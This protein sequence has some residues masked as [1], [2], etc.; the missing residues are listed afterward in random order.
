LVNIGIIGAGN[1]GT[2][3]GQIISKLPGSRVVAVTDID[4]M[5]AQ[6]LASA[7]GAEVEPDPHRLA[8]R[9]DID[10]VMITTPTPFHREY[11]EQA[12]AAGKHV[13]C[14]KPLARSFEDGQA[15]LAAA[16]R[17]GI[18]LGIGHVVRWFPEYEQARQLI[19]EGVIGQ[20]GTART[21]R[22]V[23]FPRASNN[24]YADFEQSGG[25]LLDLVIHD[26]DWLVWTFGPVR[27]MYARRIGELPEYDGAMICL[28]H[29]SGVISYAEGSWCYPS[30]FRTSL[31]IAGS[32]GV[33]QTD[34]L[35]TKPLRIEVRQKAT[36]GPSVEVPIGASR[37]GDP[38][39]L[40]DRDWLA[41]IAGGPEP[42]CTAEDALA[43]LRIA[44]ASLESAAKGKP[45][46][47]DGGMR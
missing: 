34:S 28:R 5:R 43:A 30:G 10:A 39:E 15:M 23:S 29:V 6:A 24:W 14:E 46:E 1:M 25:V 33:I 26:L 2:R 7:T 8:E 21:T 35:T 22:G 13:F 37:M 17:A 9:D 27:R 19:L 44:L 42:R 18:K 41:W 36:G 45:I 20:S 31:E 12:A 47:L 3:H 32:D 16:K 38:Y 4:P 11:V 40:E